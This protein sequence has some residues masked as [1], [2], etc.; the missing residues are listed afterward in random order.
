MLTVYD[1]KA[2][3]MRRY[4]LLL[5]RRRNIFRLNSQ[6][7]RQS[8]LVATAQ[9]SVSRSRN[10]QITTDDFD[11]V[12]KM[13]LCSSISRK[14]PGKDGLESLSPL[15]FLFNSLLIDAFDSLDD[16]FRSFL[17]VLGTG[18]IVTRLPA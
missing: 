12:L 18:K 13:D 15:T 14:Y 3:E 17:L 6:V 1:V 16:T 10:K 11:E 2:N 9:D 8:E 5:A 7:R 4:D